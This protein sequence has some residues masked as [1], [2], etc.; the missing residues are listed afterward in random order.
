MDTNVLSMGAPGRREGAAALADWLDVRSDELFLSTVTVTE[1]ADGIAKLRRI[2]A[3]ARADHLDDWLDVVLH[4]YGDRV[5]P[6]DVPAARRA[7]LLMD[8]ARATGQAPGFAD[9][10]IAATAGVHELTVLTRNIR[11]FAPLDIRVVDP[12][13]SLPD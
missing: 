2:G 4:L 6:F 3:L 11:H 13:E 7:G 10:A 12:F 9:L 5:I 1:I 8:R